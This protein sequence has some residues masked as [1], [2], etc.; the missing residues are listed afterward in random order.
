MCWH[1]FWKPAFFSSDVG[2][3]SSKLLNK[4]LFW[5]CLCLA[6]CW[7]G[8][9]PTQS[10]SQPQLSNT[11]TAVVWG[12]PYQ[13]EDEPTY[14]QKCRASPTWKAEICFLA[15][16]PD[17]YHEHSIFPNFWVS[18]RSCRV[19]SPNHFTTFSVIWVSAVIVCTQEI[20]LWSCNRD[21]V[22]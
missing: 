12:W 1:L 18:T 4:Y 13:R 3:F 17:C 21:P 11:V 16:L 20:L 2:F 15:A 19:D 22:V 8:W 14:Y 6:S 7:L 5:G 10:L 9:P